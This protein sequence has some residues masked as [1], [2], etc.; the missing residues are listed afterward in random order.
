M[1]VTLGAAFT[2]FQTLYL[3]KKFPDA[4]SESLISYGTVGDLLV[5]TVC[6]QVS[7]IYRFL[8]VS[9]SGVCDRASKITIVCSV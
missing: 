8:S 9:N 6:M 4:L 3:K 5:D 7:C 2:R 1:T